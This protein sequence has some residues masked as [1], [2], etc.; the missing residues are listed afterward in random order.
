MTAC[1][2]LLVIV[3]ALSTLVAAPVRATIPQ[4]QSK[5]YNDKLNRDA[6]KALRG[7]RYDDAL[8]IY[9]L[10]IESDPRDIQARLG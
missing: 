6:R 8:K 7:G 2:C 1:S 10:L 5:E 9:N 4:Q 3:V